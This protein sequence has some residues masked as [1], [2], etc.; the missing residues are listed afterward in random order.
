M[1][2]EHKD[3]SIL[4]RQYYSDKW[5][6]TRCPECGMTIEEK[7]GPI[8]MCVNDGEYIAKIPLT[9]TGSH[10]CDNCPIVVFDVHKI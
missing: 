10:F 5:K 8:N 1:E 6:L 7:F 2:L 4:R 3:L 9:D